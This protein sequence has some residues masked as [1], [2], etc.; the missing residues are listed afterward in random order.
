[1]QDLATRVGLKK[2]SLYTRF[3]TKE[4]LVPDVLALTQGEVFDDLPSAGG[5]EGY[6]AAL[7]RIATGLSDRSR[8]V[9]LHLAYGVS[10]RDTPEAAASVR[11]FFI[12]QRQRL[13]AMLVPAVAP[14]RA[15]ELAGDAMAR[16]EGA[17]VWTAIENDARPM[18][19]AL[20][21]VVLEA[22]QA[23]AR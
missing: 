13:A 8:C 4:A 15:L 6:V 21:A 20:E 5:I 18:A 1:M 17:T 22:R 2:A 9:G 12:E 7:E 3:P 11:T 10:P 14:G 16:L 23:I 19:R